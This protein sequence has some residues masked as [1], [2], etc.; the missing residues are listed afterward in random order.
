M[1]RRSFSFNTDDLRSSPTARHYETKGHRYL[2]ED[3][4]FDDH[5]FSEMDGIEDLPDDEDL[6]EP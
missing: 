2:H 5:H 3:D 6:D 1:G 4:D